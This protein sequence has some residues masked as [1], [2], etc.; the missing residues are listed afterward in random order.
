VVGLV[1]DWWW[2]WRTVPNVPR[3]NAYAGC[4]SDILPKTAPIMPAGTREQE[5]H[6]SSLLAAD[7]ARTSEV[8]NVLTRTRTSRERTMSN[9]RPATTHELEVQERAQLGWGLTTPHTYVRVVTSVTSP[10]SLECV[11]RVP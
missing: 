6:D 8:G 11:V 10:A 1:A 2:W 3:I 4:S 9:I 7:R 5:A